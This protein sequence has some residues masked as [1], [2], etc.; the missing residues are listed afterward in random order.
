[1][2]SVVFLSV[3]PTPASFTHTDYVK[4][5]YVSAAG[6]LQISPLDT[7]SERRCACT[8]T[9]THTHTEAQ[10]HRL[11]YSQVAS[12]ILCQW[13]N[14][15]QLLGH[16]SSANT[17]RHAHTYKPRHSTCEDLN[18]GT[19]Q[20]VILSL[21][22]TSN[23]YTHPPTLQPTHRQVQRPTEGCTG[24]HREKVRHCINFNS[25]QLWQGVCVCVCVC[26]NVN[27][28]SLESKKFWHVHL[29][30]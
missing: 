10:S 29:I 7:L 25:N 5:L 3:S 12:S 6:A 8:H 26:M 14:L 30:H 2:P 15:G 16:T 24:I 20:T 4:Q 23:T 9:H 27:K 28:L 13:I 17:L 21:C 18:W 1:M 22:D 19:L 11:T